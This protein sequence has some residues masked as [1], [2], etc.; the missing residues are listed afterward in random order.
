M[1][2]STQSNITRRVIQIGASPSVFVFIG[3]VYWLTRTN[4]F[5]SKSSTNPADTILQTEPESEKGSYILNAIDGSERLSLL[6]HHS[7]FLHVSASVEYP[8]RL[9]FRFHRTA[10][11]SPGAHDGQLQTECSVLLNC[12]HSNLVR[13]GPNYDTPCPFFSSLGIKL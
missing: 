5:N 9:F 12:K 1:G 10:P 4:T 3:V 6:F 13:G 7:S 8:S 2:N 11:P